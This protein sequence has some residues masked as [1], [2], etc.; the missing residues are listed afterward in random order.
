MSFIMNPA[1]NIF[2]Y[3][4]LAERVSQVI[5]ASTLRFGRC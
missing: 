1:I 3:E 4:K 5:A 2:N